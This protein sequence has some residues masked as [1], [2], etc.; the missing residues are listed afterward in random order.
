MAA[1][2]KKTRSSALSSTI[3]LLSYPSRQH[4][5][6]TILDQTSTMSFI[7]DIILMVIVAM[8]ARKGVLFESFLPYVLANLIPAYGG[9]TASTTHETPGDVIAVEV[10]ADD[11]GYDADDERSK[12]RR[13][14]RKRMRR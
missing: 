1:K 11:L 4:Q 10:S 8:I 7:G 13:V 12:E 9:V 6:Y 14:R 2:N 3:L 5:T